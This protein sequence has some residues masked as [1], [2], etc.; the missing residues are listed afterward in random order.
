MAT[1]SPLGWYLLGVT[2]GPGVGILDRA[3]L[4]LIAPI[5]AAA[6]GWVAARATAELATPDPDAWSATR[7]LE[8]AGALLIPA[9]L[10]VAAVRWLMTPAP[11]EWRI[12]GAVIA[13]VAAAVALAGTRN[14]RRVTIGAFA[15]VLVALIALLVPHNTVADLKR[16]ALAIGYGI[17]GAA[18]CAVIAARLSRRAPFL[19][20]TIAAV[21]L[22]AGIGYA[23]GLSPLIVCGV[24]GYALARWSIPHA[25]LALELRIYEPSVAIL[26][27]I[28]AGAA[29]GGPLIPVAVGAALVIV[30]ALGR[31]LIAGA[32]PVDS[33]LG[34][35][36][37]TGFALTVGPALGE[38]ERAV[39]TIAAAGLLLLRVIPITDAT[40][41]LTSAARGVE[42]SV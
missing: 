1:V 36:I 35:A 19:P 11:Q 12:V 40:E 31:R 6:V 39:P 17:G 4:D 37:A 5:L 41:R 29:I 14:P 24:M 8:A 25:R 15:F 33:T 28:L 3:L 10:L 20:G 27:W 2:L 18:V 23:S 21:C 42:V 13:T 16:G 32:T 38:W 9:A 7:A 26:L 34:V 30:W 22:A